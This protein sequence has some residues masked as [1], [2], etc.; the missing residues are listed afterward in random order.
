GL[1]NII[2]YVQTL[3][4]TEEDIT[5]LQKMIGFPDEFKEELRN[6]KFSGS[7]SSVKEGDIVFSNEPLVRIEARIFDAKLLQT[8]ILNMAIHESLIATTYA[9]IRQSA[10][11]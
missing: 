7:I 1:E 4:F 2:E 3:R 5:Y 11:G 8:A 6:F 9:R 10:P